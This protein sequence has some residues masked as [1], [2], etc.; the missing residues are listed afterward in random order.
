MRLFRPAAAITAMTVSMLGLAPG[1]T[2][3]ADSHSCD[4]TSESDKLLTAT[5]FP[6]SRVQLWLY[7][8]GGDSTY[9]CFVV[10]NGQA[11]SALAAGAIIV[12]DSSGSTTPPDVRLGNNPALCDRPTPVQIQNPVT[13]NVKYGIHAD[14]NTVCFTAVNT[15]QTTLTL[16]LVDPTIGTAPAIEVWRDGIPSSELTTVVCLVQFELD[17]ITDPDNATAN[18]LQC[19]TTTQGDQ[20]V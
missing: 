14:S 17:V 2:F 6:G 13:L 10:P 8:D 9:I 4:A 7:E 15:P 20:I 3:A 18:Y 11:G 19:T 16:T 1:V 12:S 5:P